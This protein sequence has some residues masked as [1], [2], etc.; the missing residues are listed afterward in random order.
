MLA[1]HAISLWLS[2]P[3]SPTFA[4]EPGGSRRRR[5]TSGSPICLSL[6]SLV[7]S[8]SLLASFFF[9]S[10]AYSGGGA[11]SDPII[12][13]L[14]V[15]TI[16]ELSVLISSLTTSPLPLLVP[17]PATE[18]M[19]ESSSPQRAS[20]LR[21]THTALWWWDLAVAILVL[22]RSSS[23]LSYYNILRLVCGTHLQ[24]RTVF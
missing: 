13:V 11:V 21:N 9:P 20:L 22:P 5:W 24:E 12:A 10:S 6:L 3:P 4:N 16:S 19:G 17:S 23:I 14:C 15:G 2:H 18:S 1:A 8:Y 7:S